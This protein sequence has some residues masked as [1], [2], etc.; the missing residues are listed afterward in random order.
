VSADQAAERLG[1]SKR[2]L[3]QLV[4]MGQ[5]PQPTCYNHSLL[6]WKEADVA[7]YIKEHE[8]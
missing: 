8:G 5:F 2:T 3:W 6:R 4:A 1:V 7:R